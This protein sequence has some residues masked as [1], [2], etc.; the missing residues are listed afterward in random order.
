ML[1]TV[2]AFFLETVEVVLVACAIVF[3][4]VVLGVALSGLVAAQEVGSTLTGAPPW[5][6]SLLTELAAGVVLTLAAPAAFLAVGV[7]AR[8]FKRFG[9]DLDERR[10]NRLQA[11]VEAGIMG[12]VARRSLTR[13]QVGIALGEREAILEEATAYVKRHGADTLKDLKAPKDADDLKKIVEAR[14]G[15][16]LVSQQ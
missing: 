9:F 5:W 3:F 7:L 10:R 6:I 1:R 15:H 8:L 2:F 12:A 13:T 14:G 11:I 16:L 4:A